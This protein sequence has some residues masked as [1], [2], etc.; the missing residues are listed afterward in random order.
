MQ[1]FVQSETLAASNSTILDKGDALD[2]LFPPFSKNVNTLICGHVLSVSS[3]PLVTW[4]SMNLS[5]VGKFS[6][7]F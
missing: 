6:I 5:K 2:L 3:M 4:T 7:E 1:A